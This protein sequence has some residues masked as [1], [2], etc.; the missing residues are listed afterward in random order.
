MIV[1]LLFVNI[2]WLEMSI[3]KYAFRYKNLKRKKK[4][5]K[6]IEHKKGSMDNFFY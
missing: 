5:E 2:V 3:K 6:L 4:K 1:F